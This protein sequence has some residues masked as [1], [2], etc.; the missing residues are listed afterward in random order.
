MGYFQH[1]YLSNS[2]LKNF[3][4][5]LGLLPEEPE[6]LQEIFDLGTLF[7]ALILEPHIAD[8][9]NK[10][11]QLALQM[12]DTF[13]ADKFCRNF[14][15]AADFKREQAFYEDRQVGPYKVKLRCKCD[16]VRTRLKA[17]LELKGLNV[18]NEKAFREALFR[19]DYDQGGSHYTI[20]TDYDFG[21]IVGISKKNPKKLFKW[22]IKKHDE[23]YLGGEQKLINDLTL[24]RD[25]SPEDVLLI[26]EAV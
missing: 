14:V 23:F 3:K 12:R 7:H 5:Q 26:N 13:W 2:D 6:N 4:R 10:D 19:F 18:E 15:M 8:L 22:I 20:T 9:A 25:Y 24:L 11:V 21:I 16:G 1:P 17:F